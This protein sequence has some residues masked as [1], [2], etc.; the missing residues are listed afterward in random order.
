MVTRGEHLKGI[1]SAAWHPLDAVA[2]VA[3]CKHSAASNTHVVRCSM[4]MVN[5]DDHIQGI[6][7]AAGY[8]LYAVV[9]VAACKHSAASN[10]H[11]AMP[12]L[13]SRC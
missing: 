6:Y 2:A 9:A 13:T 12:H 5:R 3:A 7:S 10:T 1:H 8:P 4:T 11:G